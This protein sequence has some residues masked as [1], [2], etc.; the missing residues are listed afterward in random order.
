MTRA[1]LDRRK[2][3][4]MAAAAGA[5][6]VFPD[7]EFAS[8]A[9]ESQASGVV[10]RPVSLSVNGTAYKLQIDTRATLLD[11][12][13]DEQLKSITI[14]KM[15]GYS[16]EEIAEKLGCVR[17]TVNRRLALIRTLWEKEASRDG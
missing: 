5:V 15:Q 8:A 17:R 3:L 2:F 13:P 7:V 12:L 6:T 11:T 4:Q 16:P 10:M 14:W 1:E 9:T